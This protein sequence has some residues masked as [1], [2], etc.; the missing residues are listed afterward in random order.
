MPVFIG[1]VLESCGGPILDLSGNKVK[2]VGIFDNVDSRNDL[3]TE[4]RTSGYLSV[5]AGDLEVYS[6]VTWNNANSWTKIAS[7]FSLYDH[8]QVPD[9]IDDTDEF[10][11]STYV[12][13]T[14]S[15]PD[16]YSFGIY[17]STDDVFRKINGGTLNSIITHIFGQ[18]LAEYL[19]ETTGNSIDYY[20]DNTTGVT[21][22]LNG[23]GL[24]TTS[25][26]LI[27]LSGYGA[28]PANT[29]YNILLG[30]THWPFEVP[31]PLIGTAPVSGGFFDGYE[32]TFD[33]NGF[34]NNKNVT[35]NQAGFDVSFN[36]S[37]PNVYF[38]IEKLNDELEQQNFID[39]LV[40]AN[41]A[42]P[43]GHEIY[44]GGT[45]DGLDP[46]I[47]ANVTSNLSGQSARLMLRISLFN[48]NGTIQAVGGD[49]FKDFN[50]S[51]INS[52]AELQASTYSLVSDTVD[53]SNILNFIN[54]N[55][56]LSL[57]GGS[58]TSS[59]KEIRFQPIVQAFN[60]DWVSNVSS[61]EILDMR[62]KVKE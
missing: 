50:V 45:E 56:N 34:G 21:G 11:A 42:V 30:E 43:S 37:Q 62:I 24:V 6:G 58:G 59:V 3:D 14:E 36:S 46:F 38:A 15:N 39:F 13:N 20:T 22:D 51:D 33:L 19:S 9:G 1:D 17:D 57:T 48:S 29:N 26:L 2:G 53:S 7:E 55:W 52:G 8:V 25:D 23:D 12:V 35:G 4:F 44:V 5:I 32:T 41:G 31:Q 47:V 54:N 49:T 27:L 10:R 18:E 61:F 60:V 40:N 28:A 16:R